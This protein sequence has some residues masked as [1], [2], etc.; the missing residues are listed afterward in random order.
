MPFQELSGCL[1]FS[2]LGPWIMKS[3]QSHVK[4]VFT[5]LA[6]KEG[7]T[8]VYDILE[9]IFRSSGKCPAQING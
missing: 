1:F 7:F 4:F 9:E 2:A 8:S 5:I 3:I 6:I